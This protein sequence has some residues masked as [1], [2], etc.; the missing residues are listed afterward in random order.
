MQLI[1]LQRFTFLVEAELACNLLKESGIEC[2]LQKDGIPGSTGIVQGASLLVREK[3]LENART[4][5]GGK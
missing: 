2:M 5:L 3:D 4:V 1:T